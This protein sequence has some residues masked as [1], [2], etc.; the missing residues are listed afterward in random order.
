MVKKQKP[1]DAVEVR[2][3]QRT[4]KYVFNEFQEFVWLVLTYLFWAGANRLVEEVTEFNKETPRPVHQI[5]VTQVPNQDRSLSN[6]HLTDALA[7]VTFFSLFVV[8]GH[9]KHPKYLGR[10]LNLEHSL[11]GHFFI[12]FSLVIILLWP[13][14]LKPRATLGPAYHT[15][16]LIPVS[17]APM[18]WLRVNIPPKSSLI[19]SNRLHSS[20][21]C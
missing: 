16:E 21:P 18:I 15:A 9:Q 3:R 20:R 5:H 1:P 4:Q 2:P 13:C 11:N 17:I 12:D 19:T 10:E 7:S 8:S 14:K 6:R